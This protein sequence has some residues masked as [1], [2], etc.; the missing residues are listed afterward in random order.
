MKRR[1]VVAA[2][3]GLAVAASGGAAEAAAPP[4]GCQFH[5]TTVFSPALLSASQPFSYVLSGELT[6]CASA[7]AGAPRSGVVSAGQAGI[8]IQGITFDQPVPGGVGGCRD[9]TAG[10]TLWT[11]WSDGSVT[12]L[13]YTTAGLLASLRLE[14]TVVPSK[15][16]V[17]RKAGRRGAKPRRYTIR[18]TRYAGGAASA[19]FLTTPDDATAC[20]G[21]GVKQSEL[22]GP[23]ALS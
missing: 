23:M 12:I 17:G 14:G 22:D 3:T 13:D 5:G 15:T 1:A 4:A 2:L 16:V 9:A 8:T 21:T 19:T 11:V 7:E 20:S 6:N 18:T 10:G